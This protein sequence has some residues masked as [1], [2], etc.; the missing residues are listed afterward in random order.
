[1][2]INLKTE[3]GIDED[4]SINPSQVAY[5]KRDK[6]VVKIVMSDGYEIKIDLEDGWKDEEQKVFLKNLETLI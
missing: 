1:M 6:Q 2:L 5:I 3:L 4:I